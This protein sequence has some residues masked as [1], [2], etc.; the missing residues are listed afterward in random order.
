[1]VE[2]ASRVVR[3]HKLS[4]VGVIRATKWFDGQM[5]RLLQCLFRKIGKETEIYSLRRSL[6]YRPLFGIMMLLRFVL[7]SWA[8]LAVEVR[9]L[10]GDAHNRPILT[11]IR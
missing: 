4:S 1:M 5:Q 11:L 9:F 6:G 10:L 8:S 3:L 7:D 2:F